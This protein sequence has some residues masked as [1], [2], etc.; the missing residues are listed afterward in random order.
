VA[1]KM[2]SSQ[3]SLQ[4]AVAALFKQK[5]AEPA[6]AQ[7]VHLCLLS[8]RGREGRQWRRAARGVQ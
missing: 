7:N 1:G 2:P 3:R 5:V 8:Q 6:S 4:P